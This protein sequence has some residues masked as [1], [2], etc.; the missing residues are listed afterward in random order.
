MSLQACCT[1]SPAFAEDDDGDSCGFDDCHVGGFGDATVML[2]T[3]V[4]TVMQTAMVMVA[5]V[6]G[7]HSDGCSDATVVKPVNND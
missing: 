6:N 4:T 3:V 1:G 2:A 5:V 7:C